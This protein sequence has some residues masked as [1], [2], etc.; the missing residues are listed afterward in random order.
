MTFEVGTDLR[1]VRLCSVP[2]LRRTVS[3]G[4]SCLQVLRVRRRSMSPYVGAFGEIAP[5]R[6]LPRG[7]LSQEEFC[8]MSPAGC[9]VFR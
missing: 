7:I 4:V 3:A 9:V 1:A 2:C 5:F 6:E 8:W